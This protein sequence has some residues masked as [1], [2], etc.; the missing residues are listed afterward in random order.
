MDLITNVTDRLR[1]DPRFAID[2][3]KLRE[4]LGWDHSLQFEEGLKKTVRWYLKNK[5][6]M[7]NITSS[8][9]EKHYKV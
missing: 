2:Y 1:H 6:W 9:Y 8:E 3:T 4:E 7:N 5:K